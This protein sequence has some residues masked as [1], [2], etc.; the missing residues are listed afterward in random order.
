MIKNYLLIRFEVVVK[1]TN[2]KNDRKTFINR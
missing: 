1:R 2:E